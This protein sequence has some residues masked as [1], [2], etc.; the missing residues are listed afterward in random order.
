MQH[1]VPW[2]CWHNDMFVLIDKVH[3]TISARRV[4]LVL[5]VLYLM[6]L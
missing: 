4:F 5:L 6:L 2:N 1:A 3:E